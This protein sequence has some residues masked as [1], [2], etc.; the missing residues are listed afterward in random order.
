MISSELTEVVGLADRVFTMREGVVTGEL[1][2][3]EITEENIMHNAT[4]E[5]AA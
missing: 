4:Q 5:L 3:A 2:G 1:R